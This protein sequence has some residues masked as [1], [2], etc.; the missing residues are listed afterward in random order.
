ML[1]YNRLAAARTL[2]KSAPY[3]RL[4]SEK[5]EFLL[6][7]KID[8]TTGLDISEDEEGEELGTSRMT[9]LRE[10]QRSRRRRRNTSGERTRALNKYMDSVSG[11]FRALEGLVVALDAL[12]T[13]ANVADQLKQ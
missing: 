5:S 13:W 11:T 10:R 6:G 1:A 8:V 7:A 3:S 9:R 2:A 12:E 4:Y